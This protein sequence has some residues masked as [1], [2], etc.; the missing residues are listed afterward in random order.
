MGV[1]ATGVIA[2][3]A[4]PSRKAS[5]QMSPERVMDPERM[6]TP[7]S[8]QLTNE[9][10]ASPSANAEREKQ[11]AAKAL[12]DSA[13]SCRARPPSTS[14]SDSLRSESYQAVMPEPEQKASM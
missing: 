14:G 5:H 13:S 4:K 11:A 9:A 12:P 6:T 10:V 7:G 3:A 2:E 1:C 8:T